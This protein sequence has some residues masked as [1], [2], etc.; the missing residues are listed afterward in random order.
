MVLQ[1]IIDVLSISMLQS[2]YIEILI[3]VTSVD[4][5]L[6]LLQSSQMS[7]SISYINIVTA[8]AAAQLFVQSLASHQNLLT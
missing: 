1:L 6:L 4:F 2:V 7:Y 8:R 3:F 5:S